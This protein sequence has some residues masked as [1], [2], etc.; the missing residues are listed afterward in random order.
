MRR[1]DV[2]QITS[3]FSENPNVIITSLCYVPVIGYIYA[4]TNFG[5]IL[6]YKYED[7]NGIHKN[8]GNDVLG[9]NLNKERMTGKERS[10]RIKNI[11]QKCKRIDKIFPI[12]SYDTVVNDDMESRVHI[13]GV[14]L[15]ICDGNLLY[16]DFRL[17]GKVK[18]L[19]KGVSSVSVWKDS[20]NINTFQT[21]FCIATKKKIIFYNTCLLGD[22]LDIQDI[23]EDDEE[24][25]ANSNISNRRRSSLERRSSLNRDAKDSTKKD[26]DIG[27]SYT[28]GVNS[29]FGFSTNSSQSNNGGHKN[30]NNADHLLEAPAIGERGYKDDYL[31]SIEF[32]KVDEIQIP[33]RLASFTESI[34]NIEW[35]NNWVCFVIAGTYFIMNIDDQSISDIL[36]LDQLGNNF[37]PQIIILPEQEFMLTCQDNLGAFFSFETLEPSPKSM[38]QWPSEGLTG[39]V[40]SS[41]Y[42][43]GGTKSGI[44]QIYS[45]ANYEANS[46]VKENKAGTNVSNFQSRNEATSN[47]GS[48]RGFLNNNHNNVQTLQLDDEI[49]C[50]STGGTCEGIFFGS[51][52]VMK[53]PLGP[54]VVVSTKT[55]IYALTP[56]PI[57]ESIFELVNRSQGKQAFNLL[58]TYCNSNDLLFKSLLYKTQCLVGWYEFKNLQF[59]KA[60]QSF[61]QA[62]IDPRVL[63]ILF[64]KDLI[65]LEWDHKYSKDSL[66]D[67]Y[68][69]AKLP[70]TNSKRNLSEDLTPDVKFH[71]SLLNSLLIK[72]THNKLPPSIDLFIQ[73]LLLNKPDFNSNLQIDIEGD[74]EK[75]DEYIY[76]AN[77]S[78]KMFLLHERE[79]YMPNT[80]DSKDI[81][82]KFGEQ[83]EKQMGY[84]TGKIMDIAIIKLIIN[85]FN[86]KYKRSHD[87]SLSNRIILNLL[88]IESETK[89]TE[90]I[91]D[92]ACFQK[93][94]Q[95]EIKEIEEEELIIKRVI[96]NVLTEFNVDEYEEF[97]LNHGRYDLL[98]I[99]LAYNSSYL[100]SLEIL[101]NVV[102]SSDR[103]TLETYT[104][105]NSNYINIYLIIY[106]VLLNLCKSE[107][108]PIHIQANLLKRYSRFILDK[109]EI[110][111]IDH[112][113]T[114]KPVDKF[115]L[116]IDEILGL[117]NLLPAIASNHLTRSYLE[118]II[119]TQGE[120][121]E[122]KHK[123]HLIEI[124]IND[125]STKNETGIKP[126]DEANSSYTNLF[127]EN[128]QPSKLAIML[129]DIENF[130]TEIL[131][132]HVY[133]DDTFKYKVHDHIIIEYIIILFRSNRHTQALNYIISVL[134][135]IELAEIYTLAWIFHNIYALQSENI[136][137]KGIIMEKPGFQ[138]SFPDDQESTL[139]KN[140]KQKYRKIKLFTEFKLWRNFIEEYSNISS[141][142]EQ[143]RSGDLEMNSW[144]EIL[145][146]SQNELSLISDEHTKSKDFNE[147]SNY[148]K[149]VNKLISLGVE[150]TSQKIYTHNIVDSNG[151][152]IALVRILIDSWRSS[153]ED[154]PCKA[155]KF[156]NSTINILNKYSFHP[157]I[158]IGNILQIIPGEW[159]L[160][161][162]INFLKNSL[163]SSIH[164][165]TSK[166]ISTNL[167]AIS[168][169]RLYEKWSNAR[170]NHVTITQDMICHV[171]SL[172]LGNK[173]CAIYPNGSCI[174]THCL[175]NEYYSFNS[176]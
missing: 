111:P 7:Y 81:F 41:P 97:L 171:C 155:E 169:L 66:V 124:Y 77:R 63:I 45:L 68:E 80:E 175:S 47:L 159:P 91:S 129:E 60:F 71:E 117:F 88:D 143:H 13:G 116:T 1:F 55:R 28:S 75:I 65:P 154:S 25:T 122:L 73:N 62:H 163:A 70:W 12:I 126:S 53:A 115:P 64:W 44:I 106:Q 17:R 109:F 29:W 142:L 20:F 10:I 6:L 112:L 22:L 34:S 161:K 101:E 8:S 176:Y 172:K 135:N 49:T 46:L 76:L 52:S 5:D 85:E 4:G 164:N 92:Y 90:A 99:L 165:Q 51:S 89:D 144:L 104:G 37:Q 168:F 149:L 16:L 79:R 61:K 59:E 33:S 84:S 121:I 21:K 54:M 136:S 98:A 24:M 19:C 119:A 78:L 153:R 58:K 14:I 95:M 152:L 26:V 125:I 139:N 83:D 174:H 141:P 156:L 130:D 56:I 40:L 93:T 132:K 138:V 96:G 23:L 110:C 39:V 18:L 48:N 108:T 170:S 107:I 38:I 72:K 86:S 102:N 69:Y 158:S 134:E 42:L 9:F 43:L 127:N 148:E 133:F 123:I 118:K 15:C 31:A 145:G 114:L 82:C 150:K 105:K 160:L 87:I 120:N 36:N 147:Q 137:M 100:R 131:V 157:D 67:S 151:E 11:S 113:F 140:N 57:E 166:A 74:L 35:C 30:D 32:I 173:P 103:S 128:F 2:V 167:S 27:K 94:D 146:I 162:M 3:E 50:I